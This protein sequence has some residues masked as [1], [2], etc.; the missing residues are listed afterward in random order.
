MK[1]IVLLRH[2]ESIWNKANEEKATNSPMTISGTAAL[3]SILK[4]L[5]LPLIIMPSMGIANKY[6]KKRTESGSIPSLYSG[7][8][9]SGLVP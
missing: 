3:C 6:L 5:P 9:N 2:G 1:K 8:A 4:L 7:R